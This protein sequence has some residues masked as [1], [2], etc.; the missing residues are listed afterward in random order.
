MPRGRPR[1][2]PVVL[3]PHQRR[4]HRQVEVHVGRPAAAP[5]TVE[6]GGVEVD[7]R[8]DAAAA[9]ESLET[10]H[11]VVAGHDRIHLR[12]PRQ[13]V[14]RAHDIEQG[15]KHIGDA[16]RLFDAPLKKCG[17]RSPFEQVASCSVC[18][19]GETT[20]PDA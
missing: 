7:A 16:A 17:C 2:R 18:A 1:S 15:E 6:A 19:C 13:E 9:A 3:Q 20:T 12:R 5:F 4:A 8:I 14:V 10:Q 11:R